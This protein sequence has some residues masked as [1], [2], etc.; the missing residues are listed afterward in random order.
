[1]YGD[2]QYN[3]FRCEKSCIY[4]LSCKGWGFQTFFGDRS[5]FLIGSSYGLAIKCYRKLNLSSN[6]FQSVEA[7]TAEVDQSLVQPSVG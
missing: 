5:V 7:Q 2:R 1:M 3:G 4:G 6:D